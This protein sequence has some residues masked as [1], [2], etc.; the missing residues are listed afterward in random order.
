M[1]KAHH[2]DPELSSQAIVAAFTP[3][4]LKVRGELPG[5]PKETLSRRSDDRSVTTTEPLIT[6]APAAVGPAVGMDVEI[7]VPV[8][9]EEAGL[10]GSIRRLHHYLTNQFPLTWTVTIADNASRD[11]TWDIASRLADDLSGVRA[12]HLDQKGRGRALQ[13]TW[14]AS[15]AAVVAYMDVDLSTDLNA[16]LPL[17]APLLSGTPTSPLAHGWRRAPGWTAARNAN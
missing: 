5:T 3:P 15:S 2:K 16:L 11:R 14:A 10:E 12:I 17:V 9:N 6:R 7:V 4:F 1:D 8:Y 13:A